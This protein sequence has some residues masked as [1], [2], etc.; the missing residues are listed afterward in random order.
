MTDT[1]ASPRYC[2]RPTKAGTPCRAH[3]Y[4]LM[5]RACTIHQTAEDIAYTGRLAGRR[6]G[7]PPPRP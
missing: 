7:E 6:R 2:G 3:L 5:Y 4:G 1:P